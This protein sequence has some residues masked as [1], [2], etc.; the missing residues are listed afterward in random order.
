MRD[1]HPTTDPEQD[2]EYGEVSKPESQERPP[3][4][5]GTVVD[6]EEF[7]HQNDDD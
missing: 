7:A 4:R 2:D 6:S 1:N 5:E 3:K